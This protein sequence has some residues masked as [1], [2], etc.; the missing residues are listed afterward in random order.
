MGSDHFHTKDKLVAGYHTMMQRIKDALPQAREKTLREHIDKAQ[1]KA[2]TLGELSPEEAQKIGHYLHRDLKD[3]A[4]YTGDNQQ[5]LADWMRFD[6]QLI[7]ERF[8]EMF[9]LMVDHTQIELH[10]LAERARQAIEWNSGE[11]TGPGSLYCANCGKAVH[12]HQ[13]DYIPPCPN[14]GARLFKRYLDESEE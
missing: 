13:P 9:S 1:E 4:Y 6:L 2:V 10:N 5:A 14:C 12:F 7:E 8:L 3:A 11:I